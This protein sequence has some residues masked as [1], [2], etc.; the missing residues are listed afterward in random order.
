MKATRART[1]ALRQ[2]PFASPGGLEVDALLFSITACPAD[3]VRAV[4][5][6][7]ELDEVA[8]R[9]VATL[10]HVHGALFRPD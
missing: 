6:A 7:D 5:R 4:V 3:V 9:L 10:A 1:T 8:A 2:P